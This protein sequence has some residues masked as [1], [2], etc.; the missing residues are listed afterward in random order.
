MT[1]LELFA[2][3]LIA[4]LLVELLLRALEGYLKSRRGR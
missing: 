2:D 3:A 1:T 4:A